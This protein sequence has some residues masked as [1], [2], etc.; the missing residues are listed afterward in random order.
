MVKLLCFLL[1][2]GAPE[3]WMS[4]SNCFFVRFRSISWKGNV[5]RMKTHLTQVSANRTV[6]FLSFALWNRHGVC[7]FWIVVKNKEWNGSR[8]W[9]SIHVCYW[10]AL[11]IG[12]HI[13]EPCTA[14]WG[15]YRPG[16]FV[17]KFQYRG[18]SWRTPANLGVSYNQYRWLPEIFFS[19]LTPSSKISRMLGTG[20]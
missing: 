15:L 17:S 4:W 18:I 5:K 6:F 10:I 11:R 8:D 1:G 16:E 7:C 13:I 9:E 14:M 19:G 2:S 3:R 20:F 12:S